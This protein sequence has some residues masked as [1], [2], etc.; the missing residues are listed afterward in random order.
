[1]GAHY[2]D[3]TSLNVYLFDGLTLSKL[4]TI[5]TASI[6]H[7]GLALFPYGGRAYARVFGTLPPK[8]HEERPETVMNF[9]TWLLP[10][11]A[12]LAQVDWILVYATRHS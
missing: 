11:Q 1:M 8:M 12:V 6:A 5:A 9:I 3:L 4:Q 2:K 10:R 7:G